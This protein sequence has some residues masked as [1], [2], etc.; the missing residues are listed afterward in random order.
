MKIK[1]I[2]ALLICMLLIACSFTSSVAY[3]ENESSTK[4]VLQVKQVVGASGTTVQVPVVLTSTGNVGALQFDIQYD[5]GLVTFEKMEKGELV[6]NFSALSNTVDGQQRFVFY[7]LTGKTMPAG[8]GTVATLNFRI[9]PQAKAGQSTGLQ[10]VQI[11]MSDA[12]GNNIT[13]QF[14]LYNGR[15]SLPEPPAPKIENTSSSPSSSVSPA[16]PASNG[17]GIE[18]TKKEGGG[19]QLP[20]NN[21]QMMSRPSFKDIEGHW[22]QAFIREAVSKGIVAGVSDSQFLPDEKITR[23]QFA[24]MVSRALHLKEAKN[25]ISFAD[26]G[27]IPSWGQS[28][29]AA[30]EEAGI[31]SGYQDRTF[32]PHALITR[33]EITAMAARALGLSSDSS[34]PALTFTDSREIPGW[35][36]PYVAV[37]VQKGLVKG[38]DNHQFA[39]Y[40]S[41]T[42][43]ESVVLILAMLQQK[44]K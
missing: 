16:L 26:S 11:A 23:M 6:A 35:A 2:Y 3:A 39:P 20:V 7:N 4:P 9:S 29:I 5:A 40:A 14:D 21:N 32:R 19:N 38:R 33:A 28:H 12:K 18:A 43:A 42:R 8:T 31:I 15:I 44:E 10:L 1:S 41:A 24:V 13:S 22:A 34:V 37:A 27:R 30:A 36:K 17:V 25:P